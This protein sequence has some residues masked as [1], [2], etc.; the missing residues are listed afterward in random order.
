MQKIVIKMKKKDIYSE[1]MRY[2]EN[3]K[4]ILS[5]KAGKDGDYYSDKKYVR[6][7]CHAAY[8]GVLIALDGLWEYKGIVKPKNRSL[9]RDTVRVNFY[10]ENLGKI[11]NKMLNL[12]NETVYPFLHEY[13]GYD[14]NLDVRISQTGI[15]A[16]TEIIEWVRKQIISVE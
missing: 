12:F 1:A 4:E 14:G 9:T 13:G 3:A 5:T 2:I 11:N 8:L 6:L 15:K 10:R 16:A 7:A